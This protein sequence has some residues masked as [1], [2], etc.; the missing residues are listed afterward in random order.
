MNFIIALLHLIVH[1][2]IMSGPPGTGKSMLASRFAGILPSMAEDEALEAAAL[3]SLNGNY[4][5]ENWKRRPFR[6]PHHT[7]S[8]VALVGGGCHL[9]KLLRHYKN[10]CDKLINDTLKSLAFINLSL[11]AN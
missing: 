10:K 2:V 5:L 4:K 11:I 7:A 6:A 9:Q 1:N 3:Q 8:G